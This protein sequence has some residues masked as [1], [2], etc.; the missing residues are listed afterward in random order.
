MQAN[1]AFLNKDK[2][3]D[4]SKVDEKSNFHNEKSRRSSQFPKLQRMKS[5]KSDYSGAT[6]FK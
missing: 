3:R 2:S 5:M 6:N 4:I 1:Q